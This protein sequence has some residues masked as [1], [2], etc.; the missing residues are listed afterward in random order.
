MRNDK[1]T[2]GGGAAESKKPV[3]IRNR[4]IPILADVLPTMQL[5]NQTERRLDW[6]HD[7]MLSINQHISGMPGGGS[8]PKGL[9]DAFAMLEE[10]GEAHEGQ[11]KQYNH[12]LRAAERVLNAI[13]SRTMRAF[14]VMKY[15]MDV[16]DAEIRRELN[17]SEWGFNRARKAIEEAETMASVVWRERYILAE[18]NKKFSKTT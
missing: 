7:R 13:E 1:P 8:L 9:E 12:E 11:L 17:M 15:V 3:V 4:D 2:Q 6:Q 14:V 5:V 18:G 10:A 16:P